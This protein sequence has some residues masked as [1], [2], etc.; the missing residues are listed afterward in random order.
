MVVGAVAAV[1]IVTGHGPH[2]V[3]YLPFLFLLACP[4]MHMMMHGKH[5]HRGADRSRWHARTQI[6]TADTSRILQRMRKDGLISLT[7]QH[8]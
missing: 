5:G 7:H 3:G 2:V 4:L 6:G 8:G 1:L